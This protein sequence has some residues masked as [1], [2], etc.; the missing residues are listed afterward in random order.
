MKSFA[1]RS[2]LLAST[3][4][5]LSVPASAAAG[6]SA[7]Y[8]A[9][10]MSWRSGGSLTAGMLCG[11]LP[12]DSAQPGNP[13]SGF[14][15]VKK[16]GDGSSGSLELATVRYGKPELGADGPTVDLISVVHIADRDFY[17]QVDRLLVG[18]DAV[19]YEYVAPDSTVIPSRV[20]RE[21]ESERA[22]AY[23]VLAEVL[24]LTNQV[25][26]INY[27]RQ[28]MVHADLTMR[29]LEKTLDERGE[30]LSD[31]NGLI[32]AIPD[33]LREAAAMD[34]ELRCRVRRL[35]VYHLLSP[36]EDDGPMG[37]VGILPRNAHALRV[38]EEQL[39]AGKKRIAILYGAGH[40]PDLQEH[41]LTDFDMQPLKRRWL[42]A[43]DL[44]AL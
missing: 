13:R 15:R 22:H 40:M 5:A 24:E 37:S 7:S 35:I 31:F 3:L 10:H 41:L 27:N 36:R 33:L 6:S 25:D 44:C 20:S 29:E 30:K 8:V 28:N 21:N 43:W 1:T 4:I 42:R 23:R 18:Y 32:S 12:D 17:R 19:L 11:A 38:L 14:I 9:S 26:G 39:R 2:L 16:T 34:T